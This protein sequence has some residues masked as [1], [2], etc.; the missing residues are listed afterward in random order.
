MTDD[1]FL[2]LLALIAI[3]ATFAVLGWV[4]DWLD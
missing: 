3:C 1:L 4:A 2:A